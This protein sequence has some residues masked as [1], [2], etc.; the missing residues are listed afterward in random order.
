MLKTMTIWAEK[1]KVF[2]G[3]VLPV[4]VN[5]MNI[6]NLRNFFIPASL[7]SSKSFNPFESFTPI[8]TISRRLWFDKLNSRCVSAYFRTKYV[9]F[10]M[11]W[12][13]KNL[14]GTLKAIKLNSILSI[15]RKTSL[16]TESHLSLLSIPTSTKKL[17]LTFRTLFPDRWLLLSLINPVALFR[18]EGESVLFYK[19]RAFQ[20]FFTTLRTGYLNH[21]NLQ[22]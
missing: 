3:V 16:R 15:R 4:S 22:F 7:A 6:K 21:A 20:K 19:R 18:A 11:R 8:S 10:Y 13:S 5:V 14:L 9:L 12:A 2:V 1:L 17:L